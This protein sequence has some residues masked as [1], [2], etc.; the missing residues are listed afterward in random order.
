VD[1]DR[2]GKP[3]I[4][5]Y[6]VGAS[7][8]TDPRSG[9]TLGRGTVVCTQINASG[10]L[11]QCQGQSRFAGGDIMDAGRFDATS[12]TFATAVVGGT[13]VYAGAS[14]THTGRWLDAKFARASVVFTLRY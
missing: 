5:D 3:S 13:G 12:K 9:K 7:L 6:E 11:Y 4:G 1:A 14:G 2:N 8:F 10:T